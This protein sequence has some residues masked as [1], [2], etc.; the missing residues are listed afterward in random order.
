MRGVVE[1]RTHRRRP[2][3]QQK[4]SLTLPFVT[5]VQYNHLDKSVAV[6]VCRVSSW[7]VVGYIL[8]IG[9]RCCAS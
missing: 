6:F 5:G 2:R 7:E 9:L 4:G 3:L 8:E 1:A